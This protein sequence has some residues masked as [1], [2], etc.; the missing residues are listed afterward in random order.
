MTD[1]SDFTK[2]LA[3]PD[4]FD[5]PQELRYDDV[6]ARAI[7]RHDVAEDVRGINASLDLIPTTRGGNWPT[8]PVT[9]EEII[10]DEY[11]HECEFRDGKSFSFILRTTHHGYIGCAYFYPMGVRRP[12]TVDLAEHDVDVSWWVTPRAYDDGYYLKSFRALQQW[13]TEDYA[14]RAPFYSNVEIPEPD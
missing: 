12:L 3:L 2:R 8:G 9:D 5:P 4:G 13:V 1:Y 11:W 7:S 6:T 14:F 10:V